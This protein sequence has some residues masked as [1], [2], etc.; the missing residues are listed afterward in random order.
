MFLVELIDCDCDSAPQT[1]PKYFATGEVPHLVLAI[2]RCSL[3]LSKTAKIDFF[4]LD[5]ERDDWIVALLDQDSFNY[6]FDSC[7]AL[8]PIRVF[9]V[10]HAEKFTSIVPGYLDGAALTRLDLLRDT[11]S[12]QVFCFR[13]QSMNGHGCPRPLVS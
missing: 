10:T 6:Q 12:V 8:C 7:Q 11:P 9:P 4:Q 13:F 1:H 3:G 5:L 2:V